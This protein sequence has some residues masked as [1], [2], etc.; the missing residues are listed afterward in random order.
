[1]LFVSM[2]NKKRKKNYVF[3]F[4]HPG[5]HFIK[6]YWYVYNINNRHIADI[7][8]IMN[9]L[10]FFSKGRQTTKGTEFGVH[11]AICTY[12]VIQIVLT[13]T[14]IQTEEEWSFWKNGF[15]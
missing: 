10:K 14:L 13:M 9:Y 7:L 11:I 3:F 2:H 8:S 5:E 15:G 6:M 12:I 1:M 4:R